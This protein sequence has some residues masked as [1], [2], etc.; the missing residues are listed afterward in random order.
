AEQL[1]LAEQV[2]RMQVD[3]PDFTLP[4]PTVVRAIRHRGQTAAAVKIADMAA[5][6]PNESRLFA[7]LGK[8]RV[9]E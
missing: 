8:L 2:A 9:V 6:K 7:A 1:M 4:E 3:A 5:P